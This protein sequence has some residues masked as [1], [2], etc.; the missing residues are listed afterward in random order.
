VNRENNIFILAGESSGDIHSARL[1]R[2]IKKLRPGINFSG[3][4][5]ECLQNENVKL[6]R[7]Y[8]KVNFIGFTSV[9]FNIFRIKKILNDT[10][11]YIKKL[12]PDIVILVDFPGFNL[13]L[14][15]IIR[16]FYKG[17]IIYYISPQ[18]W[19]W[20]KS[21][22]RQI[23]QYVDKMLVVFPFEVG[24]YKK[25]GIE[26]DYVGHPLFEKVNSFLENNKKE[27]SEQ[28]RIT[29]LPGSR[30]EEIKKILPVL[31][32]T[33]IEFK[34]NYNAII[35]VLCPDDIENS[36]YNDI[37]DTNGFEMIRNNGDFRIQYRVILNSDLL[38]VKSGTS[39][40]ETA[41]IGSP[42]CV[43]YKT[44]G[45]NYF[46]GKRLIQVK[47]LA[48]V[49]ILAGKEIVKEYIQYDMNK[50]NLLHEGEKILFDKEYRDKLTGNLNNLK[51]IF[52]AGTE[53]K[54][55]AEIICGYLTSDK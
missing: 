13:K 50:N 21:R 20:H 1:V 8:R 51:Q 12:N 17:K 5:G 55:A 43:V 4:G 11:E 31:A 39:T 47:H 35:S 48:M 38:F 52:T 6:I 29:L 49:N 15:E 54:D 30:K 46:L 3:I 24:F 33:A 26:A 32:E 14:A 19:A 27:D 23:K 34:K 45:L 7:H 25:E 9:L 37:T 44:S 53:T 40:L 2:Q 42:F 28:I 36:F 41:L 22:V 18:L 16:K 10:A